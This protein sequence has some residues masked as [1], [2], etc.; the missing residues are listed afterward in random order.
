ME[1]NNQ[2][3]NLGGNAGGV[4]P[5]VNGNQ[6]VQPPVFGGQQVTSGYAQVVQSPVIPVPNVETVVT[7]TTQNI[8]IAKEETNP[9]QT[10]VTSGTDT[11]A[12][13]TTTVGDPVVVQMAPQEGLSVTQNMHSQVVTTTPAVSSVESVKE[14]V[15]V[16]T[17]PQVID[18][19]IKLPTVYLRDL[20]NTAR[21]VGIASNMVPLSEVLNI[22]FTESGM[23]LRATSGKEDIEILDSRYIFKQPLEM[24]LDIKLF[25]D[26][27]NAVSCS[28]LIL[29]YDKSTNILTIVPDDNSGV[30]KLTQK[31]DLSTQQ[32]VINEL[33]F[34]MSYADMKPVNYEE[35]V[36]TLNTSKGVRTF[37]GKLGQ[38]YLEGTYYNDIV[39]T[40]DG[41]L[42]LLQANK[43]ETND[44]ECFIKSR[45]CDLITTLPFDA[46]K[47]RIGF[48]TNPNTGKPNGIVISDEKITIC[49]NIEVPEGFPVE[50]CKNYWNAEGF[51]HKLTINTKAMV[52]VLKP[53]IPFINPERDRDRIAV[54]VTGND[55][56]IVSMNSGAKSHIYITN[57]DNISITTP[58]YLPA[59]KLYGML[60]TITDATFDMFVDGAENSP[61][62]CLTFEDY[63]CLV[64]YVNE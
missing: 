28:N 48:I 24:S 33:T 37:A 18:G 40:S 20:V 42:M 10:T 58:M 50:I 35:L 53:V 56:E 25:G 54:T 3:I 47:F 38:P 2:T 31:I 16:A 5:P 17:E 13:I 29:S 7:D 61:C 14:E 62:M 55:M 57:T 11:Q 34:N 59:S 41:N 23:I 49:D 44:K 4:V 36:R 46:S 19:E 43:L 1:N 6:F 27:V 12:T 30:Y 15:K 45:L 21:K 60:Q 8:S 26:F 63:K 39:A 64:A 22:L 9:Q 51:I 52:D 32:P